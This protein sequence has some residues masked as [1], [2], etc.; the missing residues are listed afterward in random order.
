MADVQEL[1]QYYRQDPKATDEAITGFLRDNTR[2]IVFGARAINAHLPDWLDKDTQDWDILAESGAEAQAKRL[3][4]TLD[5]QYGGDYFVVE[6]A[7]HPGTFKVKSKITGNGVADITVRDKVVSF[8][9]I[10]GINYVSLQHEADT[11]QRILSDSTQRFRH[12]KDRDTL[13]RIAVH[14]SIAPRKK[15]TPIK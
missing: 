9:T 2:L 10:D 3:E 4:R 11:A 15:K 1:E 5:E 13:Q 8:H 7:K 14:R 6:A 12:R